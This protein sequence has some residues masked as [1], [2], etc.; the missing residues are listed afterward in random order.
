MDRLAHTTENLYML[1]LVI[2]ALLGIFAIGII[3]DKIFFSEEEEFEDNELGYFDFEEEE[4][5]ETEGYIRE[6]KFER[7][8]EREEEE[9][10]SEFVKRGMIF[11]ASLTSEIRNSCDDKNI[12]HKSH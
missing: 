4:E 5:W 2:G 10:R 12:N 7:E 9:W 3:T 6:E 11:E 8:Y 1:T